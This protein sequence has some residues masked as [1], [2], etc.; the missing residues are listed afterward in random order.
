MELRD[1][2]DLVV[3]SE[4]V[5]GNCDDLLVWVALGQTTKQSAG[6]SVRE[7]DLVFIVDC[8][9]ISRQPEMCPLC[10]MYLSSCSTSDYLDPIWYVTGLPFKPL[11]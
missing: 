11:S 10:R 6:P 3:S 8:L 2:F 7:D 5:I 1:E 9:D 4:S